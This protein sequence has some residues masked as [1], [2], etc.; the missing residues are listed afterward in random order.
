MIRRT[1]FA[2]AAIMTIVFA[3]GSSTL[4]AHEGRVVGELEVEVGFLT[5][6]A[7]E[8][9]AN[10]AFIRILK[11]AENHDDGMVM[12]DGPDLMSHG[13][14]FASGT[15]DA[16]GSFEVEL[17]HDLEDLVV[18][19][20]DHLTG[21]SGTIAVN[22]DGDASETA[23]VRFDHDGFT[24]SDFSVQPGTTVMFMNVSSDH[25]MSVLSGPH[26]AGDTH[27][28]QPVVGAAASLQVEVTHVPTTTS[29]TMEL[30]PL[31]GQD[32][33]YA[34]DFVPTAPGAY[35]FRF[36]GDIEGE[37]FDQSF[38]SGPGTFDEIEP[39]RNVQFP[40]ELRETREL[41]SAVEGLQSELTTA[42]DRAD[43]ADSAA[44]TALVI[45]II[46]LIVG[47]LGA[48]LGS[49]GLLAARRKA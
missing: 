24:P 15:V 10:G 45:G 28:H 31:F 47:A 20:H 26:D 17:G 49:Y 18:P 4:L 42:G 27:A 19:F 39:A 30:R 21:S 9:Q 37:T 13:G 40:I 12:G 7:F 2:M 32:G 34:A 8:G 6:P 11:S 36:F 5:E 38:T 3:A 35:T 41:Q 1:I 22:H 23:M 46:G 29:E 14:L 33:S 25:V 43:D 16:G 48:G 44:S